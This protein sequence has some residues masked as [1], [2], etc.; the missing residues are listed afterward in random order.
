MPRNLVPPL[1]PQVKAAYYILVTQ[2]TFRSADEEHT[3]DS[4]GW[5]GGR[6]HEWALN[7]VG[8]GEV[9]MGENI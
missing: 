5:R 3:E 2:Y 6:E 4:H 7:R 1:T 8:A 9:S